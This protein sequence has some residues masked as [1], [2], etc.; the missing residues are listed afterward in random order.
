MD[1]FYLGTWKTREEPARLLVYRR[2]EETMQLLQT[3][4]LWGNL[5]FLKLDPE[6][7]CLYV[8]TNGDPEVYDGC[9]GV[10][11]QYGIGE[12]GTLQLI[13][14]CSTYGAEPIEL[15]LQ[16]ETIAVV[17]H[18]STTNRVCR[19]AR[20]PDGT[21][22]PVWVYDEASLVLLERHPDGTPGR[23]LD[24]YEFVGQ[25]E[26]PFFQESAAPHSL[27][28]SPENN[29]L[30]VPER[31]S[32]RTSVFSIRG[33]TLVP[34]YELPEQKH[35]GPRNGAMTRD[36][37][38]IYVVD[39]IM[40]SVSH[41]IP[42]QGEAVQRI[43]TVT[44]EAA[45]RCDRNIRSFAAPHPVALWLSGEERYLYTA[46]RSTETIS[47]FSRDPETG[48][49][50]RIQEWPLSGRNPRQVLAEGNRLYIIF[51]D[52]QSMAEL[53]VEETTGRILQEKT[54]L[55]GIPA[56]AAVDGR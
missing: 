48:D 56:I 10:L 36:G 40:P 46:T 35:Y 41:Y 55:N 30:L 39:E 22:K 51:L 13:R 7:N 49:L 33:E 54:I 31:G 23:L 20:Q 44:P 12:G 53:L 25:G 45:A 26:I 29:R 8:L 34:E 28:Y 21:R 5:S 11:Q 52:S 4:D 32:E 14:K 50:S 2:E 19:T 24:R 18:G 38:H 1:L 16:E 15:A 17:N 43:S 47:V 27:F 42:S 9:G 3:L 37:K 6:K